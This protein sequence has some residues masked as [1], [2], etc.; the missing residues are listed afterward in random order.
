[1]KRR[2]QQKTGEH[3][4]M[5]MTAT[6]SMKLL[7]TRVCTQTY[8]LDL[9]RQ[10]LSEVRLKTECEDQFQKKQKPSRQT[11]HGCELQLTPAAT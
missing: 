10:T 8:F 1:M 6:E 4:E 5:N 11:K 7:C 9:N 2:D 3:S